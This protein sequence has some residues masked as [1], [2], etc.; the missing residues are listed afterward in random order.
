MTDVEVDADNKVHPVDFVYFVDAAAVGA[1]AAAVVVVVASH[2]FPHQLTKWEANHDL[3]ARSGTICA[4][5]R[6]TTLI[7][8]PLG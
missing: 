4:G 8:T 3:I 1:A 6:H 2:E 7:W 5:K